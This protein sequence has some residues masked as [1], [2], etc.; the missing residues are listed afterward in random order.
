MT[1]TVKLCTCVHSYQDARYGDK[2]RV[3]NYAP[4][5]GPGKTPAWR[6]VVC[7]AAK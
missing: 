3:H 1:T 6:C 2:L 5:G 4:R 7:G